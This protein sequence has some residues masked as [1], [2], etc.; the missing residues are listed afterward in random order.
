MFDIIN[1]YTQAV[2]YH[3]ET[4]TTVK[5]AV[6]AAV[7]TKANLRDAD[8]GGAYLRGANL[9]DADLG[10]ANLGGAYLRGA[11]LR[12]ADLGDAD[13]GGAD[14]R[15]ANL[16]GAN[17]GGADLRGANLRGA[18]LRDANLGG[19]NL[20]GAYLRGADLRDANLGG[21]DLGGAYL[22][23]ANLRD[24][25]LGGANLRD[26]NLGGADLGEFRTDLIAEILKLPDELENLRD[27]LIAGKISGSTYTGECACLAGTIAKHRGLTTISS[28]D[29]MSDNA[30]KFQVDSSSPREKWFLNV[31]KGDTPETS[32][33]A[34][35]TLGWIEEAIAIRDHIR[36]VPAKL[37]EEIKR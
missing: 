31:Q 5:E 9:R 4:A 22:R 12:D 30:V 15:D 21:A 24:A 17:L 19:A 18:N 27:Q 32:Q 20:G 11:N 29:V 23:G 1:R 37:L 26:A 8:L 6:V 25:D 7:A 33:I 13:L 14:L 3:S 2:L 34:K 10:G 28:G 16:G 36:A 35:I